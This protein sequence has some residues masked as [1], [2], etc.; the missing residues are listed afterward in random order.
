[1]IRVARRGGFRQQRVQTGAFADIDQHRAQARDLARADPD[2]AEQGGGPRIDERLARDAR[3]AL[4]D[5]GQV[6]RLLQV[7]LLQQ[8]GEKIG[9]GERR[10]GEGGIEPPQIEDAGRRRGQRVGQRLEVVLRLRTQGEGLAGSAERRAGADC[11]EARARGPQ[12]LKH[13]LGQRIGAGEDQPVAVQPGRPAAPRLLA[14]A[15]LLEPFG[16]V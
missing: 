12:P 2:R 14:P 7:G 15:E 3:R 4:G 13:R 16:N 8:P 10:V 6:R 9:A 5:E 11:G 1:M